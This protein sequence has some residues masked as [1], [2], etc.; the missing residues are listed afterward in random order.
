MN[1]SRNCFI[2][3]EIGSSSWMNF[4]KKPEDEMSV[5]FFMTQVPFYEEKMISD[6]FQNIY[7]IISP[8][9]FQRLYQLLI[10]G[11]KSIWH[12]YCMARS[13]KD[14]TYAILSLTEIT[15]SIDA[16]LSCFLLPIEANLNYL[17]ARKRINYWH[18][19]AVLIYFNVETHCVLVVFACSIEKRRYCSKYRKLPS[20]AAYFTTDN[21]S[22]AVQGSNLD[23]S[24]KSAGY[25]YPLD[26][27]KKNRLVIISQQR[28]FFILEIIPSFACKQ[29]TSEDH[30][31]LLWSIEVQSKQCRKIIV[32]IVEGCK[33]EIM[34]EFQYNTRTGPWYITNGNIRWHV[35]ISSRNRSN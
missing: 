3:Y 7:I 25:I 35:N 24:G 23:L 26:Y 15:S 11:T 12:H 32:E 33:D 8:Q 31:T 27:K 20:K 17:T 22:S 2:G 34:K 1:F 4:R 16:K 21:I 28:L 30:I 19:L 18:W 6:I 9:I 10:Y 29:R 14:L 5:F 13:D